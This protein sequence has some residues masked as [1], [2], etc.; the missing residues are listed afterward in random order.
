MNLSANL[1]ISKFNSKSFPNFETMAIVHSNETEFGLVLVRGI[2]C[3][4]PRHL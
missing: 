4:G 3:Y 1:Y 2:M